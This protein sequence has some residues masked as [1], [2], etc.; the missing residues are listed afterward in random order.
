MRKV[1]STRLYQLFP[2]LL[3]SIKEIHCNNQRRQNKRPII[4]LKEYYG[5]Y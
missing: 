3:L 2:L 4:Y 5:R 1:H